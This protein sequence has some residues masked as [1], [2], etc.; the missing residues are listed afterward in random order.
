MPTNFC[1]KLIS[2]HALRKEC[3]LS[4]PTRKGADTIFLSTHSVR[5]ATVIYIEEYGY[6]EGISIHALR[7]ECDY[8]RC[9]AAGDN[10]K[11][12]IHALRKECDNL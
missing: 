7:K 1:L 5:S 3:D 6:Y 4:K 10:E 9:L 8:A 11:I 12:S 2:I